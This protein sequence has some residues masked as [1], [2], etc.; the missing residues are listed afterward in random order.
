MTGELIVNAFFSAD[1]PKARLTLLNQLRNGHNLNAIKINSPLNAFNW[2][3]EFP[4]VFDR[5]NPGFDVIVGNPPFLGGSKIS[6]YLGDAYLQWLKHIH[7][8]SHGNA[9]LAAHFFRRAF[10]LLREGGCFGLI[11]TNTISQ[12][13]TRETGLAYICENGGK[14]YH[15]KTRYKWPGVAAVIVSIVHV[16]KEAVNDSPLLAE[17]I[18][19]AAVSNSTLDNESVNHISAYLVNV[20]NNKTPKK[21]LAN[22]NKS[23][24]GSIVLGMGFTFD[25]TSSKGTSIAEMNRLI[26]L[27]PNNSKCI[28]PYIGGEE[29]NTSPTHVHHRYVINFGDVSEDEARQYP[30]LMKIV[31]EKVKP[32]RLA[33]KIKARSLKWWQHADKRPGLYNTITG[34]NRVLASPRVTKHLSFVFLP[35]NMVYSDSLYIFP[36]DTYNIFAILQSQVHEVW[37]RFFGSSME[38]SLRYSAT[39]TFETFPFP[40]GWEAIELLEKTGKE[41]YEYRASLMVENNQGLTVLYNRYHNPEEMDSD[42]VRLRE[43]HLE[44]DRAVLSAYGWNDIEP[45]YEFSLEHEESREKGMKPWRY[46]WNKGSKNKVLNRLWEMNE[47]RYEQEVI[48]GGVK[49]LGYTINR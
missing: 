26:E 15:A 46:G 41:Y 33:Q 12:G 2:E 8:N 49:P 9:D 4:E 30:D 29:V 19:T 39:D 48:S 43:L 6:T 44:M 32:E 38:D 17:N 7:P 3:I 23:F 10:Y 1:K 35:P 28:F 21:L 18:K 42:I 5:H 11:A 14:I 20:K 34:L 27:N 31:E 45:V 22:A 24:Q 25:D 13:D 16:V 40:I 47:E 36:F 37:A